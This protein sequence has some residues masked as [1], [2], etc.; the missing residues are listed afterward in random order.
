MSLIIFSSTLFIYNFIIKNEI[1]TN[2]KS[3]CVNKN[4][5]KSIDQDY[6]NLKVIFFS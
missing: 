3:N 1:N 2:E 5:Q 6:F 4:V